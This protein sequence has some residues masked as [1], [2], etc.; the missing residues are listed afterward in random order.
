MAFWPKIAAIPGQQTNRLQSY[1]ETYL[2]QW[3][4]TVGI[5][6]QLYYTHPGK[7]PIKSTTNHN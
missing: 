4:E 1:F 6:I 7:I 5:N 2:D 3:N